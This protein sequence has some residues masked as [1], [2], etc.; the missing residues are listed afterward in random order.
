[1]RDILFVPLK[2]ATR[3]WALVGKEWLQVIRRPGAVITLV[4][5]PFAIMALFGVGYTGERRPLNTAVIVGEGSNVP[6]D[7]DTYRE[8]GGAA[9]NVVSVSSDLEA[10]RAD[11]RGGRLDLIVVVPSDAQERFQEGQQAVIDVEQDRVDPLRDAY[12]RLIA[13]RQVQELNREIIKRTAAA[14]QQYLIQN[15]VAGSLTSISPDVIA[16]PAR[17]EVTNWAPLTPTVIGFFAPAVLAL[18]LQHMAVTLTALSLVR[19][20]L[21][22]VMDLY[23]VAPVSTVEVLLGTYGA[24]GIVSAVIAAAVIALTVL[25]LGVPMLSGPAQLAAAVALLVFA[26]L[27]LGMLISSVSDSERQAVQ[28]SMLVL[29]ASVFFSG[30]V[31]PLD[32]FAAPVAYLAYL[33]PVTHGIRLFQDFMLRGSTNAE[34][35]IWALG[36]IGMVLFVLTAIALQRAMSRQASGN[37]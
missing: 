29:L 25:G 1:M 30:F 13:D 27:G 20:R 16:S 36:V 18:V 6:T 33:L 3:I 7:I 22:G 23:R 34:W 4:F 12:T 17:A 32:E 9:V 26:S 11:L 35:E 24:Y 21:S 31:L 5:A 2:L 15:G 10:A 14:G 37:Q 19:E 28:L 8:L